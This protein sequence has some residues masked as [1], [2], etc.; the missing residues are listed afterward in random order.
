M[1]M[2]EEAYQPLGQFEEVNG[3]AYVRLIDV[4]RKLVLSQV[5]GYL[6]YQA[7]TYLMNFNLS[8]RQIWV[9]S[10]GFSDGADDIIGR[11]SGEC[12][13]SERGKQYS[14][15]MQKFIQQDYMMQQPGVVLTTT[16]IASRDA[17]RES[18]PLLRRSP[19]FQV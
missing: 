11:I 19:I 7:I 6:S 14:K 15:A 8:S 1:Q 10:P 16:N 17:N 4:G 3:W 18:G 9:A 12:G 5:D 13:L 2:Y